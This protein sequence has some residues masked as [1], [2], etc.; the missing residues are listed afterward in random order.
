MLKL[1]RGEQLALKWSE[2]V[3]ALIVVCRCVALCLAIHNK[4]AS[5]I[6]IGN[7]DSQHD[8]LTTASRS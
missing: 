6:H 2:N 4:R 7:G 8:A 5:P 3:C 1:E